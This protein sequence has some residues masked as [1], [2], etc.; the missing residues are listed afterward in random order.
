MEPGCEPSCAETC[1]IAREN[2]EEQ[3]KETSSLC[4]IEAHLGLL[5]LLVL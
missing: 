4:G 1:D 5:E 2:P 3:N